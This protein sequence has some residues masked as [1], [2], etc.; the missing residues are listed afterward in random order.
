MPDAQKL[1]M[2]TTLNQNTVK[3]IND[4]VQQ[5]GKA[6]PC[7]VVARSGNIITVAFE[8]TNTPLTLPQVTIPQAISR[9]AQPPTQVGD[10]GI[11]ASCDTYLGGV[12]GLGGGTADLSQQANLSTLLY[13][14]VSNKNWDIVSPRINAYF[15]TA[16]AGF[17]AQVDD[18]TV[19]LDL[20]GD[21]IVITIPSGKTLTVNGG[22]NVSIQDG[23]DLIV[24]TTHFSTHRHGTGSP[25]AGTSAPTPGT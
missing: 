23:G 25:V 3:R 14:P 1:W 19:K 7:R 17:I 9:Y 21:G 22:G 10:K 2:G 18:G 5:T 12:S 6:L 13:F 4:Q 8:I 11:V 15:I 16:P 24:G 20:S